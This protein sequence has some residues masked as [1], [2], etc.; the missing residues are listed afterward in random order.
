VKKSGT[1]VYIRR[2][3]RLFANSPA[4]KMSF[5]AVFDEFTRRRAVAGVDRRLENDHA[6]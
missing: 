3:H 6:C 1:N 2:G 5:G 4:V